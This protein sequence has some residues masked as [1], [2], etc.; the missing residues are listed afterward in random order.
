MRRGSVDAFKN[1]SVV[2]AMVHSFVGS[3]LVGTAAD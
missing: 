2:H 3:A 1:C